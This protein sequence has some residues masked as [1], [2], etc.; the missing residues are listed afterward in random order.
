MMPHPPGCASRRRSGNGLAMSKIRKQRKAINTSS[1]R[2]GSAKS[3]TSMPTTSS[4][5]TT[6]GSLPGAARSTRVATATPNPNNAAVPAAYQNGASVRPAAQ[7]TTTPTRLPAVPGAQGAAP[8]PPTE[9]THH[10]HRRCT[11][12]PLL[13]GGLLGP[14]RDVRLAAPRARRLILSPGQNGGQDGPEDPR[15]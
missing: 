10:A 2:S 8:T 4:I 15:H 3:A 1:A 9:A 5:T 13:P 6:D 7:P 11:A 14:A 12:S